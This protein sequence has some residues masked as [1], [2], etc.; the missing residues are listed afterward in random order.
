MGALWYALV[1]FYKVAWGW[2]FI[3]ILN[4][5]RVLNIL[6]DSEIS[7]IVIFPMPCITPMLVRAINSCYINRFFRICDIVNFTLDGGF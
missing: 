2:G 5:I 3:K 7:I 4:F 1:A 6:A